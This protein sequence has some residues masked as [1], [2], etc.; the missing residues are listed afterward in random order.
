L[1]LCAQPCCHMHTGRKHEVNLILQTSSEVAC[2]QRYASPFTA[3][4]PPVYKESC[5]LVSKFFHLKKSQTTSWCNRRVHSHS[6]YVFSKTTLF[7]CWKWCPQILKRISC[8]RKFCD[9]FPCTLS[10]IYRIIIWIL[11]FKMSNLQGLV[12]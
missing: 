11:I 6:K 3:S 12:L 8:W 2:T 4:F 1:T 5:Q 7:T 9:I 10:V